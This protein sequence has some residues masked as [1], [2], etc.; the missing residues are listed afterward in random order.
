[1]GGRT[2]GRERRRRGWG[3]EWRWMNEQGWLPGSL[4]A[5]CIGPLARS[6]QAG[7]ALGSLRESAHIA[8]QLAWVATGPAGTAPVE[9]GP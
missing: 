8:Q 1:M 4:C 9:E 3:C 6:I 5:L 2:D 7:V